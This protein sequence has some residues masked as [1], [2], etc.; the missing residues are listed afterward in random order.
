MSNFNKPS[1]K[2]FAKQVAKAISSINGGTYKFDASNFALV[3]ADSHELVNLKN[4]YQEHCA[5][6]KADTRSLK[7]T[8]RRFH[9][10]DSYLI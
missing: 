1:R 8:E 2:Q 6:P 3:R 9:K 5:C 10:M 4:L 7:I